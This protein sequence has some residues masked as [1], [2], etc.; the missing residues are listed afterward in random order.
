MS[1][2]ERSGGPA[3]VDT[4]TA[5]AG[6]VDRGPLALLYGVAVG[7]AL[8]VPVEFLAR[9]SFHVTGMRGWG[10]HQQPPGTWSDDTSLTLALADVMGPDG[11]DAAALARAFVAWHDHAAYTAGGVVFDI[12][13]ATAAAIARLRRGAKPERAG[14]TG[15][16]DNGN[17]SLM[18]VA[19]LAFALSAVADPA[20]RLAMVRLVSSLTHAHDC[21]VTACFWYVE[22][23]SRLRAGLAPREAYAALCRAAAGAL[24][25]FR[26]KRFDRLLGGDIA[27]LPRDAIRSSGYVVDTLEAAFW[28][29]LTTESYREAVLTAVNLGDDTDTTGAVTGAM[30]ALA[31]GRGSIPAEWLEALQGRDVIEAVGARLSARM[32]G[33][34]C[35]C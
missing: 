17:G 28:C 31:W 16:F 11:V 4:G 24:A 27:D 5:P 32:E 33:R 3:A 10:T 2:Q 12:G 35:L 9:D 15:D 6:Q 18:R 14:G 23:C 29:L 19:P 13:N 7:D 8:G 25:P 22:M 1:G 26:R 20:E 30:A 34:T 21:S